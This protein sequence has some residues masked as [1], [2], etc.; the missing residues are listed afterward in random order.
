MGILQ[1]PDGATPDNIKLPARPEISKNDTNWPRPEQVE[2]QAQSDFVPIGHMPPSGIKN[3]RRRPLNT[4]R[5][6]LSPTA[7][8]RL[9][10]NSGRRLF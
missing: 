9:G 1:V 3:L 2:L 7:T 6:P 10:L 8:L 4:T 5:L